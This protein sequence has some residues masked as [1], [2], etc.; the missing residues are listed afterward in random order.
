S[1]TSN[2]FKVCTAPNGAIAETE[3]QVRLGGILAEELKGSV[4]VFRVTG[5]TSN[6]IGMLSVTCQAGD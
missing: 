4:T 5:S 6:D 3:R 1:L 2:S